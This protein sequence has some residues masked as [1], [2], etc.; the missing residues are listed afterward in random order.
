MTQ[1]DVCQAVL[2]VGD[3][4]FDAPHFVTGREALGEPFRYEIHIDVALPLPKPSRLLGKDATLTLRDAFGA[5]TLRGIVAEVE[6]RA[7]DM[8]RG[9]LRVIFAPRSHTLTLGRASRSF[10]DRSAIDAVEQVAKAATPVV[11]ALSRRYPEV[12]YRVQREEDDWSFVVRTL[13][14]EGVTF[15]Y[16]HDDD[17]ALVLADDT[18][19]SAPIA[20]LSV[21][22]YLRDGIEVGVEAVISLAR[23]AGVRTTKVVRRSFS[24]KNP[25]LALAA[26]SG[27]GRYEAYDA[28]GGGPM[29]EAVLSRAVSDTGEA[30]AASASGVAGEAT[31]VRLYPGRTFT[32]TAPF[33]EEAWFGGEWLITSIEVGL[34]STRRAFVTRFTAIAKD[35]PHR[36]SA[37][38]PA[39]NHAMKRAQ[40]AGWGATQPGV[41][42]GLVVADGGDEVFPDDSARVRVQMHWDRGGARDSGAGTWMRVAQRCTTGSMMFPRTGW[43]VAT[44][45]EEGSVDAPHVLSR[46]HDGERPPEY[47]LPANKTRVVYKTA[48]SP[49]G[50]SHNELHFED[51]K[52]RE[53]VF[54]NASRDMVHL[55]KNDASERIDNDAWHDVGVNQT[56]TS[57]QTYTERVVQNQTV[58]I[59]AH[60]KTK[61]G[62]DR[63]TGTGKNEGLTIGGNRTLKVGDGASL[64]VTQNRT[65][66]VG[67]AQIDVSLGQIGASARVARTTV[68]GAVVRMT[69]K[70]FTEETAVAGAEMV[71]AVKVETAGEN[72]SIGVEKRFVEAVGGGVRIDAGKRHIDSATKTSSWVVAGALTGATKEVTLEGYASIELRCGES[73]VVIEPEQIRI[74]AKTLAL[75]GA[76]LEAVTR[77]ITH[78]G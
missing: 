30:I 51:A 28:A 54:W 20:G 41:S 9:E 42:Y 6:T 27:K 2:E 8:G 47:A 19:S 3:L 25:S 38:D 5:R 59:G 69:A 53:V 12:P 67:A 26:S 60:Q 13:E 52:G 55:T 10:Q 58:T 78:N 15:H 4:S 35:V 77:I 56:V 7:T 71:G 32:I 63:G 73:A 50:G 76:E 66:N 14:A 61:L 17:S 46:I 68:G 62:R 16:D 29:D 75:D 11:R 70:N 44:V 36:K 57:G 48:T 1:Q 24:W 43:I 33:E 74:E 22:P 37:A 45:N 40:H 39:S 49:G 64:G 72:R 18:R 65:V 21:L 34:A 23:A 31:T